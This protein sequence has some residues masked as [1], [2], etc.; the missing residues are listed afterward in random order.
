MSKKSAE[1]LEAIGT[2]SHMISRCATTDEIYRATGLRGGTL[3]KIR[4][5][6]REGVEPG[7]TLAAV[8]K[9]RRARNLSRAA[10]ERKRKQDAT[11]AERAG[12]SRE[13]IEL[14]QRVRYV[15]ARLERLERELGI[16]EEGTE[17]E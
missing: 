8:W 2:A 5:M 1:F 17:R 3:T 13:A 10:K 6:L 9:E 7:V 15:E 4:A 16:P 12:M 11:R 14:A